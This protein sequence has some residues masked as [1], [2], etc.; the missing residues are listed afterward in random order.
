[1][2]RKILL[3]LFSVLLYTS[4]D[5]YAGQ[6]DNWRDGEKPHL[7]PIRPLVYVAYDESSEQLSVSF[8]RAVDEAY[9]YVYK[10]GSLVGMD[11]LVNTVAGTTYT[12]SAAEEGMYTIVLQIGESTVTLFE[13]TI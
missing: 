5:V 7:A 2:K 11:W 6:D 3:I 9:L 10:D 12:Y 13:E 8:R 1:M 4:L